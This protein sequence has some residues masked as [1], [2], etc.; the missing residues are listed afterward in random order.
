MRNDTGLV[1]AT[2]AK[3]GMAEA[4]RATK[5]LKEMLRRM[6][7]RY[8]SGEGVYTY[9]DGHTSSEA[10]VIVPHLTKKDAILLGIAFQQESVIAHMELISTDIGTAGKVLV[11]FHRVVR[12]REVPKTY[13]NYTVPRHG[14]P[15][16]LV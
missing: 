4:S 13:K 6:G 9:D 10:V 8:A 3:H 14:V 16:A 7:Y 15:F 1:S 2:T 5:R 11:R 12:G